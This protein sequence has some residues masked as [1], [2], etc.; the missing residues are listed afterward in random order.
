MTDKIAIGWEEKF[1]EEE[2]PPDPVFMARLNNFM[3]AHLDKQL[4]S[5]VKSADLWTIIKLTL[6]ARIIPIELEDWEKSLGTKQE[7]NSGMI[8]DI[9]DGKLP[10]DI[11]VRLMP[12][13]P[14]DREIYKFQQML[15]GQ[16]SSDEQIKYKAI[17]FAMV[18][19]A[20]IS[21]LLARKLNNPDYIKEA[22][23]LWGKILEI[24]GNNEQ[25]ELL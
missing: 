1:I 5:R 13:T 20:N 4:F 11:W 3:A 17:F 6:L 10:P 8:R 7:Y 24:R 15:A 9:L 2:G 18:A 21:L 23:L 22:A 19:R 12:P 16:L 14:T 25:I